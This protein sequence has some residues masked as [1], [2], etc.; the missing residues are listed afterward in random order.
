MADGIGLDQQLAAVRREIA[1]RRNVY[2]RWVAGGRMKQEKADA[3]IATMQAVH[4]ALSETP[5]RDELVAALLVLWHALSRKVTRDALRAIGLGIDISFPVMP[6][7][8]KSVDA[9]REV[10]ARALPD[11]ELEPVKKGHRL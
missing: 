5:H 6:G 1:L 10:L 8:I 11:V 9:A 7:A 3:E 4:D 2:P